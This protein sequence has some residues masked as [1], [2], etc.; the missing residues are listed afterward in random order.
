MKK[1]TFKDGVRTDPVSFCLGGP[2]DPRKS[3]EGP[4]GREVLHRPATLAMT[5]DATNNYND[6]DDADDDDGDDDYDWN[7]QKQKQLHTLLHNRHK[8]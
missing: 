5:R 1:K 3:S 6:D 2:W 8:K 7:H 4:C